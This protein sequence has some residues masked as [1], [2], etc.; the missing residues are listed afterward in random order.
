[1]KRNLYIA[2]AGLVLVAGTA[3]AYDAT[4]E[5]PIAGYGNP[6]TVALTTSTWTIVPS[7]ST[8]LHRGGFLVSVPASNSA[9]AVA[10]I[11]N[12]TSTA[13][14]TTKRPIEIVKGNGFTFITLDEGI[15]LWMMSLHTATE[16]VHVQE[17]RQ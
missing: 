10:H 16:N 5:M 11:G 12:C 13:I 2:L 17:V 3:R 1:M 6:H 8:L 14:L 7:S 15:C 9:N 4:R